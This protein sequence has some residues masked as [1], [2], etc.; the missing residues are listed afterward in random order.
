LHEF[1]FVTF[2]DFVVAFYAADV[3]AAWHLCVYLFLPAG[4]C[5][6]LCVLCFFVLSLGLAPAAG[7]DQGVNGILTRECLLFRPGFL[8][9]KSH[10][11]FY[12][13][14]TREFQRLLF[15]MMI[16]HEATKD[17]KPDI[18]EQDE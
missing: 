4:L 7:L 15:R 12:L 5:V 10:A 3:L 11:V 18:D 6:R 8:Q 2:V 9:T 1:F 13:E 14:I 16:D 17:T